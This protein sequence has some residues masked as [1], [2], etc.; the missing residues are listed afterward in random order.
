MPFRLIMII[1]AELGNENMLTTSP[2]ARDTSALLP[3]AVVKIFHLLDE[4][5]YVKIKLK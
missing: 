1:M 5:K 2:I 4:E 3:N